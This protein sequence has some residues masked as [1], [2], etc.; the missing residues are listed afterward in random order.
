MKVAY[1]TS[2][3]NKEF[4]NYQMESIHLTIFLKSGP[5]TKLVYRAILIQKGRINPGFKLI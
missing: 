1:T 5:H 3:V 2:Y 4:S